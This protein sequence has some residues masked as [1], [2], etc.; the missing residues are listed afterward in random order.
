MTAYDAEA[1][2][3]RVV[4]GNLTDDELAALVL[5]LQANAARPAAPLP[6]GARGWSDRSRLLRRYTRA[7]RGAWRASAWVDH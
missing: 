6:G 5:V 2:A 1:P 7:G 4:K 3:V